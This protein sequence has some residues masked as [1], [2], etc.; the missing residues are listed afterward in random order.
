MSN[1]LAISAVSYV[2]QH[3]LYELFHGMTTTFPSG[4]AVTS[5]APDQVQNKLGNL[6]APERQLNLFMHQVTHNAA[7]RNEGF[8]S[9]SPDG[10]TRL[11]SPPLALDLHYLLT[12]YGSEFWEAEAILGYALMLL[13]E[14]PVIARADIASAL[15]LAAAKFPGNPVA[16]VLAT[17]GLADQLEMIKITPET[18]GREE[19]AWLWT[20]LKADYRPTFPFQVTVV[21]MQPQVQ[22]RF[23]LPVLR[24]HV[25]AQPIQPAQILQVIPPNNQTIAASTDP[26]QVTG[27]FLGGVTQVALTNPRL[28]IAFTVPVTS[29]SSTAT[30]FSFIPN[31]AGTYPPGIYSL[32]AQWVNAKGEITQATTPIPFPLA[33]TLPTQNATVTANAAGFLVTVDFTPA[34]LEQQ[35]V[36]LAL[37]A[38]TPVPPPGSPPGTLFASAAPAAAF[39]GSVTSCGFQFPASLPG[40]ATLLGRILVD[41]VP[42]QVQ[43]DTSGSTPKFLG[44]LVTV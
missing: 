9:L 24:R 6:S 20:A 42:S 10:K 38:Y 4:I 37:S 5:L 19:L 16:Q 3:Y 39:T 32:S 41:S 36:T 22:T 28:N 7:W 23:P 21:L 12:V 8:P 26:V 17:S 30:S 33:P 13:H 43:A 29:G 40:G 15:S 18:L 31:A 1:G 14:F 2:L 35:E 25:Q 34:V 27:L 44:P 11:K